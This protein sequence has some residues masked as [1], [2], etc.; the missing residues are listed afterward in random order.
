MKKLENLRRFMAPTSIA[1]FGGKSMVEAVRRCRQGGFEGQVWLINPNHN[2]IDG[3]TCFNSVSDLP[4]PVDASF[5]GTN[6]EITLSIV[7]QLSNSG[8]GGAVCYASGFAESGDKGK[9]M[10]DQLIKASGDMALLGPNCY[11]MLNYLYGAGLWPVAYGGGKVNSGVAI[12][13]QSGNFGYNISMV[14]RSLPISYIASV[15][16]QAS[17]DITDLIDALLNEPRVTAIGLHIEGLKDVSS[18]ANAA[19]RALNKN[20]PIVAMK[21]GAS[22]IG[23][24]LAISHT[25]SLAGSDELYNALFERVGIIRVSGPV[26]FIETMKIL[27]CSQ[28][29][30]G[31]KMA[32]LACSGGDAGFIADYSET[33]DL[34]LPK[35]N[36]SQHKL[37]KNMLPKFANITN[38]LDF[39][40]A[41]WG[42]DNALRNC[43]KAMLNGNIDF[44]F[45]VLDYPSEESG[46]RE[47]CDLIAEIFQQVLVKYDIPG[48]I[49][50]T[51]PELLPKAT[52]DKLQNNGIPALQGVED[53]LAAM[54]RVVKYA[55]NRRKILSLFK[56]NKQNL[57]AADPVS[58]KTI[59]MN[60]WESKRQLSEYG[61][62]VP[63]S[64]LVSKDLV[65]QASKELGCPV[66]IKIVNSDIL[67]KTEIG[68]VI[69]NI[70][71]PEEAAIATEKMIKK[72]NFNHP[73][74]NTNTILVEKMAP[75]P[76]AELI[77]GVKREANF[78]FAL[79]IG[80]GG[81]LVELVNDSVSL[82]LPT[83]KEA[84]EQALAKLKVAKILNGFRGNPSGDI[85]KTVL[86]I[87]SIANFA[88]ANADKLIELD[89]NPLMVM[90]EGVV[91]VD[92]YIRIAS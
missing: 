64:M 60:E 69:T 66:A 55:E 86:A 71:S 85:K 88:T 87:M 6:R 68:A 32:A 51:F 12:L 67:H 34:H 28:L 27:S 59:S 39:T 30:K 63:D 4:G 40:T 84:V 65:I 47:Q 52:R 2:E 26:S 89:V 54:G 74:I 36:S 35:L 44:G 77:I 79:V 62:P 57:L 76:V 41:I 72:I 80:S 8:G 25:N 5:I 49:A 92:A 43:I 9:K 81:I 1:F 19:M 46:E 82:L 31:S 11:G 7:Q 20:I 58:K 18:F 75:L 45:L 29:P 42:N 17:V 38:P 83:N 61:L 70:N 24:E 15:G 33:N 50:S 91:A 73:H 23:N 56:K 90:N 14:N 21:V 78:G 37:L 10:Q 53:G 48:A 13:T 3:E 16:N 22:T